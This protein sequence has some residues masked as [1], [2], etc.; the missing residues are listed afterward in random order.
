MSLKE[1]DG[2][3]VDIDMLRADEARN[4]LGFYLAVD[5][6]NKKQ[7]E[8]MRKKAEDWREN[9]RVGQLLRHDSWSALNTN[10]RKTMEYLLHTIRLT[11]KESE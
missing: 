5:G 4:I 3:R 8:V 1:K 7:V 11:K 2:K 6:N 10:I 9:M